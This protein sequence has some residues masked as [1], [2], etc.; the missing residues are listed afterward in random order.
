MNNKLFWRSNTHILN[1][2]NDIYEQTE[3]TNSVLLIRTHPSQSDDLYVDWLKTKRSDNVMLVK[4]L[5]LYPLIASS[6]CVISMT[7]TVLIQSLYV[8]KPIIQLKYE[9]GNYDFDIYKSNL[10]YLAENKL[11]LNEGIK[12]AIT[13]DV[14]LQ[15]QKEIFNLIFPQ[16]PAV[17]K[18][19]DVITSILDT[20]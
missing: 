4:H 6:D 1:Y 2:L 8:G 13:S 7:S 15:T 14:L 17:N 9:E 18:V 11:S 20:E 16:E 12:K 19:L 3:Q 10:S 5:S